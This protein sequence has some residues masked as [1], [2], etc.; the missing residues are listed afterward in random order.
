MLLKAI[1]L[2]LLIG[3]IISLGSGLVFLFKDVGTT[4]RTLNSLAVR[5]TLATALMATTVY[6]FMSGQ[7]KIGAPWD[8]RKF[9]NPSTQIN[10]EKNNDPATNEPTVDSA[11]SNTE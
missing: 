11:A 4:R 10:T 3:L 8:G 6:G 1:I 5:I 7:L 2:L 9:D